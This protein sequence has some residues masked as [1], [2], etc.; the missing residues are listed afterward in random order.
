MA[1][2]A[3]L[4]L[5]LLLAA[6][7]GSLLSLLAELDWCIVSGVLEDEEVLFAVR[8][9]VLCS[10][11][12]L[13]LA[14][15]IAVPAAWALARHSFPGRRL[16][17]L[18]LDLP[19][20]TPPLV[21]GMGLLLFLGAKGPFSG[22]FPELAG[23]L[24]SPLGVII[25][26]TYVA[27]SIM[28]R[29]AVSAFIS[30]DKNYVDAAYNLGLTPGKA[31]FLVEIPMCWR[32][33]SGGCILALARSLGEFGATLMLAG[34]TRMQTETLPMAVFLNISSGDFARAIAC[35][36]L[37]IVIAC[38]LLLALH[39]VQKPRFGHVETE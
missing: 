26:Q 28:V 16:L 9:S 34:A 20:V 31:L 27:S 10:L 4:P 12:S 5:G 14:A 25:A 24:F 38:V 17:D 22:V 33:L 35:A 15:F 11:C 36:A 2:L 7:L 39:F 23:K 3:F 1:R 21:V 29:S 19:M 6:I 8:M 37:L 30:I 13:C 32:P 18:L